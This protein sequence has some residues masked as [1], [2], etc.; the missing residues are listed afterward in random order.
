VLG[1]DGG[2]VGYACAAG[3]LV[4]L[5]WTTLGESGGSRPRGSAY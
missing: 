2:V 3:V 5:G 4:L 1:E